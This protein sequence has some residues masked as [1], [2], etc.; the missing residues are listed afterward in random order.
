MQ[1]EKK[2]NINRKDI[3][4]AESCPKLIYFL[5]NQAYIIEEDLV[6]FSE[7]FGVVLYF[8]TQI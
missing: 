7:A 6:Y 1:Q 2:K 4:N 5:F 3:A 8:Y